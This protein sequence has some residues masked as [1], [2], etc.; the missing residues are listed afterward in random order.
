MHSELEAHRRE[1]RE[2][3]VKTLTR[4][5]QRVES[6]SI[7]S[8]L[9]S[10]A[11]AGAAHDLLLEWVI[12]PRRPPVDKLIDTITTLWVRTLGLDREGA[13]A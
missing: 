10:A 13:P 1:K 4:A 9:L 5:T 7:D 3:F 8:R 11:I 12:A 2:A 6:S